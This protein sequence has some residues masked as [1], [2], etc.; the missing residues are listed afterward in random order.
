MSSGTTD[1]EANRLLASLAGKERRRLSRTLVAAPLGAHEVLYAPGQPI[2]YVYFPKRGLLISLFQVLAD[3]RRLAA[4]VVGYDGVAG[5]EVLLGGERALFTATVLVGG[6]SFRVK[7][8][9]FRAVVRR[10]GPLT[11]LLHRYVQYLLLQ[12][13]QVAGCNRFHP[14]ERHFCSLLLRLQDHLGGEELAITHELCARVLGVRRVGITQAARQ[15]RHA[16][17]IRYRWG[18]LTIL[19]RPGLEAHACG[20]HQQLEQAYRHL[21][22]SPDQLP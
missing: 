6:E 1:P 3:G 17:L 18:K 2:E 21:L 12:V 14:L 9:A 20:C 22:G 13:S 15:L 5:V 7:A 16:G 11:A 8:D 19:D 4:G 10:S